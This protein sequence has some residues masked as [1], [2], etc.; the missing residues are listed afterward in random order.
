MIIGQL[1]L[2]AKLHNSITTL[3]CCHI[4]YQTIWVPLSYQDPA[5]LTM[6]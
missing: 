2:I 4:F 6:L 5:D 3:P 1:I